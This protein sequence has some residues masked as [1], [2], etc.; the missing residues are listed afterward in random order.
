MCIKGSE[1]FKRFSP[2]YRLTYVRVLDIAELEWHIAANNEL[3]PLETT[4][5]LIIPW[6]SCGR[7][8]AERSTQKSVVWSKVTV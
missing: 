7:R 5:P 6:S 4:K 1:P 8:F 2:D 3:K